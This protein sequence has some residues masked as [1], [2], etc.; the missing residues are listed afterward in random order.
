MIDPDYHE[1]NGLLLHNGSKNDY[2]WSTGNPLVYLL[3]LTQ[4]MIKV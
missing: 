4:S 3:V 2:V 1:E